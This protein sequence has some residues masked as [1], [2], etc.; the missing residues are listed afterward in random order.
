[1][2]RQRNQNNQNKSEKEKKGELI[3]PGFKTCYETI[4]HITMWYGE[5]IGL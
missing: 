1:M 3:L 4:I 5:E 2:E